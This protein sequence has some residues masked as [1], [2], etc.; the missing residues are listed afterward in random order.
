MFV[1]KSH[2]D[3]PFVGRLTII[4]AWKLVVMRMKKVSERLTFFG[5]VFLQ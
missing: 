3:F 5:I 4:S 2:W 1:L